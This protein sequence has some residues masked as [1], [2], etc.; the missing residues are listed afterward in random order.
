MLCFIPSM[1]GVDEISKKQVGPKYRPITS[2]YLDYQEVMDKYNDMMKWLAEV[3]VNTLN[4]I[5]YMH[6]KYCYEKIQMALHDKKVTRWFA[7]GIAGLSGCSRFPFCNK[8]CK[9]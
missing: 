9:G 8:I 4:V 7:T 3:Y 2:E 1:G 6:D 5:H